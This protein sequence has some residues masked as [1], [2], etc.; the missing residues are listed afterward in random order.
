MSL[1]PTQ[2]PSGWHCEKSKY[3]SMLTLNLL[4]EYQKKEIRLEYIFHK[5][6][7]FGAGIVIILGLL[8]AFIFITR[9]IVQNKFEDLEKIIEAELLTQELLE[10]EEKELEIERFN[11]LLL[12][13]DE[14]NKLR[15]RWSQ[16]LETL[17]EYIPERARLSQ[18]QID[19]TAK[20]T[21]NGFSPTRDKVLIIKDSLE[22]SPLFTDVY[23]PRSNLVK[24][25][26]IDFF[27][28]FQLKR[29]DVIEAPEG[30]VSSSER[31]L[32]IREP[33]DYIRKTGDYR[34]FVISDDGTKRWLNMTPEEFE[35]SGRVWKMVD[36]VSESKFESYITGSDISYEGQ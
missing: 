10:V 7:F 22:S 19:K 18:I 12:T 36:E 5:I 27:F 34:V 35:K 11:R 3:K 15:N 30:D 2:R 17:A 28:S 25:G 16:V 23:S 31:F 33:G 14:I 26:D 32:F 29:E 20:I 21:I 6:L 8:I 24:K 1:W 9:I 13:I 4:P